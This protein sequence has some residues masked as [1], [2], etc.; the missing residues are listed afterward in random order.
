M[1]GAAHD[2]GWVKSSQSS[3]GSNDCV[4]VRLTATAIRVR[5]SKNRSGPEVHFDPTAWRAFLHTGLSG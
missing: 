2:T 5:D 1:L 3:A 4:E